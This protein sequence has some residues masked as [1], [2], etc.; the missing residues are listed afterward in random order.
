MIQ[1]PDKLD[2]AYVL[3]EGTRILQLQLTPEAFEAIFVYIDLLLQWRKR[4]R[5]TSLDDP[6]RIAIFHFLDSLTVFKVL[7]RGHGFSLLDIGT[8]AGFP[9]IVMSIADPT[10]EVTLMD[11]DVRK[12]V[13]LKYAVKE[14]RLTRVKFLNVQLRELL[15]NPPESGF[16]FMVSR[17]FSSDAVLMDN[18]VPLISAG[19][20]LVRMAG[21]ASLRDDFSLKKYVLTDSWEGVLPFSNRFRR[22]LR[23]TVRQSTQASRE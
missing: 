14:L 6:V 9:G 10:L 4:A 11:R 7:P 13:F 2:P 5:L 1:P 20:S 21:P 22:V 16:N 17:A 15:A 8:G 18:L 19:G 12:I 3:A 23:Y